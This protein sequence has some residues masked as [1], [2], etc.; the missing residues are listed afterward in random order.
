[1]SSQVVR[2]ISSSTF[3]GIAG[4]GAKGKGRLPPVSPI[5]SLKYSLGV[6]DVGLLWHVLIG[7]LLEGYGTPLIAKSASS[8]G[9]LHTS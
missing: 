4:S 3:P 7:M 9:T 8:Y 6:L 1:M 5:E 2:C